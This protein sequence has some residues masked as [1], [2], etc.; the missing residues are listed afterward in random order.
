MGVAVLEVRA[1][2]EQHS[3]LAQVRADRAIGSIELGVDNRALPAEPKPVGSVEAARVNREHRI[4]A[5]GAAQF[6][7][8]L[9]MV[10]RHVDQPGALVRGDETAGKE[11]TRLVEE[12]A[13][14]AHR[15]AG[16]R[17]GELGTLA[18]PATGPKFA[19]IF[20]FA[21][22][23]EERVG[24]IL[25]NQILSV[26]VS[27]LEQRISDFRIIGDALVDRDR[28]GCGRPH[29]G[30]RA[31]QLGN[32]ALDN[33]EGH[34][35]LRRDDVLIFDL[36]L[37]ERGL[38]DRRPHHRLGA[39]V[40]LAC[41]GKLE[42]FGDDRRLGVEVH[43]Q[44]GMR[45]VGADPQS[46]ELFALDVH[47]VL[48]IGAALGS[49]LADRDL[50]LVELLLSI[51][52][53]HLP[54]DRKP[55]AVPARNIRGILAEQGLGAHDHVLDRMVE[56]MADVDVAVGVGR[57]VVEDELLAPGAVL[58]NLL[59]QSFGFPALKDRRLL[60]RQPGLHRKVGARK[61]NRRTIVGLRRIWG[62]GHWRGL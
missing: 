16:N 33:L 31:D 18:A 49:K 57:T 4:N 7:I 53:L 23:T 14:L 58:A 52:L 12:T 13:E 62:V 8:V 38:L 1:C 60:L 61:E 59:V 45:P 30:I 55:V 28:P 37:G 56:R 21:D 15:M 51:L 32:R 43:R 26:R 11:R 2:G 48:G 19:A 29:H 41:L 39:A 44:I 9:A 47:P 54:L 36:C 50:I 46:L 22:T 6:E 40:E 5:I 10:G 25:G 20:S 24:E 34:V 17:T 3:G 35:D 27:I 42:Q